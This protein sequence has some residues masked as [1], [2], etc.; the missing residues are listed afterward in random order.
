MAPDPRASAKRYRFSIH[1]SHTS[2]RRDFVVTAGSI[3][4]PQ[5]RHFFHHVSLTP[6]TPS[7][8]VSLWRRSSSTRR[9]GSRISSCVNLRLPLMA[10]CDYY[11]VRSITISP[12]LTVQLFNMLIA[13][14]AVPRPSAVATYP[15]AR[16]VL[17]QYLHVA[18]PLR[19]VP[20]AQHFLPRRGGIPYLLRRVQLT[21]RPI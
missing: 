13:S 18:P 11:V 12:G 9:P 3:C 4:V 8:T 19:L 20:H 16:L 21:Q 1:G 14:R 2:V 6:P 15:L 17:T 5:S 10:N 7:A